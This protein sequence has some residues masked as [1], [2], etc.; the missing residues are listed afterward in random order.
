MKQNDDALLEQAYEEIISKQKH[1]VEEKYGIKS[2]LVGAA[3]LGMTSLGNAA[4]K[5]NK[6]DNPSNETKIEQ[7]EQANDPSAAFDV[8]VEKIHAG[9]TIPTS[10]IK[11]IAQNK[12]LAFRLAYVLTLKQQPIPVSLKAV[13]GDY[14]EKLK[15]SL[16]G[17]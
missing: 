16:I 5:N 1:Y 4:E 15:S 12:D 9:K 17:P 3:A 8:A 6:S 2:A 13:V 10:I 7:T 14:D 11:S